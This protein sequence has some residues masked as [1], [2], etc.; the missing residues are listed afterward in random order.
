MKDPE[1]ENIQKLCG[2]RKM[3]DTRLLFLLSCKCFLFSNVYFVVF[4]I[5]LKVYNFGVLYKLILISS[6]ILS[7]KCPVDSVPTS[8]LACIKEV[9]IST[10]F[11][12]MI[13]IAG[14]TYYTC[15][16]VIDIHCTRNKREF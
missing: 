10:T 1:K 16:L 8:N 2:K 9:A 4:K 14:I 15:S 11:S 3:L 12:H 5:D 6:Y 7:Q 13:N